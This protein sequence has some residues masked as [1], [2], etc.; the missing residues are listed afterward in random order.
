[1]TYGAKVRFSWSALN[2]PQ[3]TLIAGESSSARPPVGEFTTVIRQAQD[4]QLV[5]S[6]EEGATKYAFI[7]LVLRPI[8]VPPAPQNLNGTQGPLPPDTPLRLTWTYDPDY[9]DNIVGFRIYRADVDTNLYNRMADESE[10]DN[11][12]RA[13]EDPD[14][15]CGHVYYV[16]AVYLD[17]DSQKQETEPSPNHWY[18]W[19]CPTPTPEP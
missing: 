18:S 1:V 16:S 8:E 17:V 2:V 4:Y 6:N 9:V 3:V 11:T 7:Q 10:L 13:W 19:P 14:P 5:A 12:A 15:T